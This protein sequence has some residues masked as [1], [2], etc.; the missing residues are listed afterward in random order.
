MEDGEIVF[1]E[2]KTSLIAPIKQETEL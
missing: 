1:K 2:M